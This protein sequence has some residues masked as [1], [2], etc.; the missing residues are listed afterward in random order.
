MRSALF[1]FSTAWMVLMIGSKM[2]SAK[3]EVAGNLIQFN[4]NG[5]WCWYQDPRLV[6]DPANDTLLISSIGAAE[7][8]DGD[9]R[10]GDVD[11]VTYQFDSGTATRSVLHHH[12]DP[13]DDHNAAALLIRPDGRYLAVYALHN[14]ENLSYWRVSTKPHDAGEWGPEQTFDWST[15][16]KAAG[17]HSHV[18]YS[19]LFYLSAEGKTYDFSRAINDDP[20]ILDSTNIGDQWTYAGKLLT[21]EKLGYVNGYT[22]YAS[23]GVDRIDFITTEHHPRDYNN[24]IYHG[25]IQGGKLHRS[26]GSVVEA[27]LF[28]SAG[29][30]QT[31]LTRVFFANSMFDGTIMTHAWTISLAIDASGQ[32]YGLISARA[33]DQPENSNFEDH[34]FFYVRFDGKAWQVNELAKAGACLWDAEQDYTGLAA[35]D[36]SDPNIVFI[37]TTIDPRNDSDL[38]VHEIFRG[39]TK[40]SGHT[41]AWTAITSN[42][43]VQNLRPLAVSHGDSTVLVWFR[44][45]MTR[46]QHYDSAMVGTI[47][48]KDQSD[49][50][51]QYLP[52]KSTLPKL[53]SG[54]YNVYAFFWANPADDNRLSAG[55]TPD[56][57]MEFRT[58]SC[59][60]AEVSQFAQPVKIAEDNRLLYRAFL[61]RV[62]A[63]DGHPPNISMEDGAAQPAFAGLGYQKAD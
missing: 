3:D 4:E 52:M 33:N 42:S 17:A 51:I 60:T 9:A 63:G 39:R 47:I 58:R 30:S 25:Y 59:Q 61:G 35:L 57:M 23:N 2:S 11:V 16:I 14:R 1:A 18:T 31:E 48:G 27:N 22:K 55:L 29:H 56:R 12:F 43:S 50:K 8:V 54:T 28:N 40:D 19:N 10:S 32:P 37:S 62:K 20:S 13:Q 7:G 45:T 6:V 38:G 46:S 34:R 41:W 26:D 49:E 24:S 21:E 36:P 53:E 5:A 44:G 15:A